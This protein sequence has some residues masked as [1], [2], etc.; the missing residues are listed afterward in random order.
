MNSNSST[1]AGV[2][3]SPPMRLIS[4]LVVTSVFAAAGWT[5]APPLPSARSAH[6]VV[7]AAGAIHVL[8]GPKN[9][10][11]DRFDGRRWAHESTLPGPALN[12][13]A[14]AA[15]GSRI[16]VIGGFAGA[17]NLPVATVRVFDT[18]SRAWST[19]SDL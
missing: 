5:K 16:Y 8:G 14:V 18:S 11:V 12:A 3:G 1:G 15:I 6:G 9:R 17:T 13:P 10:T 4:V 7:V 19:A 2:V